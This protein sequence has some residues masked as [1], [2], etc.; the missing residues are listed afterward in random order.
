MKKQ[1]IIPS[2][3]NKKANL[4]PLAG[5]KRGANLPHIEGIEEPTALYLP[6]SACFGQVL[7]Q[8]KTIVRAG[9]SEEPGRSPART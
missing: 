8:N 6:H 1:N 9:S 4:P 7:N 5:D 2:K 3:N